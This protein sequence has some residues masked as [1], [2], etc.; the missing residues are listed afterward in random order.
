MKT[1]LLCSLLGISLAACSDEA[2]IGVDSNP[3]TCQ[4]TAVGDTAGSV[5]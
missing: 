5:P 2:D 3:I 4:P 1:T